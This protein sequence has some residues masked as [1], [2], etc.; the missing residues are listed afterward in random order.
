MSTLKTIVALERFR[1]N[2]FMVSEKEK[3]MERSQTQVQVPSFDQVLAST[4]NDA[5][6]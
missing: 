4:L 6:L 3:K 1:K 2:T 5:A